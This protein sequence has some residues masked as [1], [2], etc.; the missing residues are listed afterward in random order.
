[1]QSFSSFTYKCAISSVQQTNV[2]TRF[3]HAEHYKI[4]VEDNIEW[5]TK[6]YR[7]CFSYDM[8]PKLIYQ[9]ACETLRS[10]EWSDYVPNLLWT[11]VLAEIAICPKLCNWN[12]SQQMIEWFQHMKLSAISSVWKS[13]EEYDKRLHD[14]LERCCTVGVKLNP[15]KFQMRLDTIQSVMGHLI[16]RWST[17][18]NSE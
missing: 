5:Y 4:I 9:L 18:V 2:K 1:M 16:I 8:S 17:E 10:I 6:K 7:H 12:F 3:N 15:D 11:L 13:Q 14:L